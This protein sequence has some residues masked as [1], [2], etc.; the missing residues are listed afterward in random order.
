MFGDKNTKK[1]TKMTQILHT[2]FRES[3]LV[4]D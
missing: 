2:K 4:M 3:L 1:V